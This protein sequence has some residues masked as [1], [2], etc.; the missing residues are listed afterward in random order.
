MTINDFI[1]ECKKVFGNDIQY[2]ATSKDG[3]VFKTKGWRDDKPRANAD[4]K[5]I[6]IDAHNLKFISFGLFVGE[7]EP[8]ISPSDHLPFYDHYLSEVI[9]NY[10][11]HSC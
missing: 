4:K 10:L 7:N 9:F 6:P 8:E 2:K 1:K 5:I 3:Q 11:K